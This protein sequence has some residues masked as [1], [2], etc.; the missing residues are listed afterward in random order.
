MDSPLREHFKKLYKEQYGKD[1][2][3]E[4][5]HA[6]LEC[7]LIYEK[8]PGIDIVSIGPDMFGVHTIEERLNISSTIRVY[9]FLETIIKGK[10]G[11]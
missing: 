8:L 5:I 11:A 7:G 2:K 1:M 6:G 3:V 4:A 9:K 10:I